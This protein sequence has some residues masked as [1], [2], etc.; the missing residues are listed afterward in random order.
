MIWVIKMSRCSFSI[1]SKNSVAYYK[2]AKHGKN[3]Y[4]DSEMIII[5]AVKSTQSESFFVIALKIVFIGVNIGLFNLIAAI[6]QFL[7]SSKLTQSP[8]SELCCYT[9]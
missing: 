5:L 2:K 3:R 6:L 7:E 4:V 8:N 1:K 9:S